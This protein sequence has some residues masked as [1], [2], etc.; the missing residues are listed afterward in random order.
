MQTWYQLPKWPC[1]KPMQ[2]VNAACIFWQ[3]LDSASLH[4]QIFNFIISTLSYSLGNWRTSCGST[5]R[6]YGKR[7]C[8]LLFNCAHFRI[9]LHLFLTQAFSMQ[10]WLTKCKVI[11]SFLYMHSLPE[12]ECFEILW[13]GCTYVQMNSLR[14]TDSQC[15]EAV[16]IN[17]VHLLLV[18]I[19]SVMS[20]W[21]LSTPT[22]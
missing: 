4:I 11:W 13:N 1:T 12:A 19:N 7:A 15:L 3:L 18:F 22:L 14:F 20:R 17:W 9:V 5:S 21:I 8:C 6:F 2:F 10:F 16:L